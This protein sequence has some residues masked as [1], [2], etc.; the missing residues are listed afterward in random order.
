MSKA[1]HRFS[2]INSS[3]G[4]IFNFPCVSSFYR[5]A[6][7]SSDFLSHTC[8]AHIIDKHL[9]HRTITYRRI[10]M[11]STLPNCK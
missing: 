11:A 10:W 8:N 2:L 6:F 4:E 9:S 7:V 1:G 5:I 3:I